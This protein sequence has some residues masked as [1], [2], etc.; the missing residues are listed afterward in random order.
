[1]GIGSLYD[2]ARKMVPPNIRMFL[3][4]ILGGAGR[5]SE[6]DLSPEYLSRLR[7]IAFSKMR[8]GGK[9]L[10][11]VDYGINS[12]G[13]PFLQNI[14]SPE[15][16]LKTLLGQANL[17]VNEEGEMIVRDEFDFDDAKDIDSASGF[18]DAARSVY[19]HGSNEGA[20]S[21]LR[22]AATFLGS[23]PG[24]GAPIEINLG[25]YRHRGQ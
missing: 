24:E 14:Q 16:N 7:D 17:D 12:R 1:M 2:R 10:E 19:E 15:Y 9:T 11:Y 22:R 4:D 8:Q 13:E 25:R 5:F 20:Y 18:L 23:K 6:Q 21:A 3:A